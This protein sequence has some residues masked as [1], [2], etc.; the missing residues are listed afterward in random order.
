MTYL[1]MHEEIIQQNREME[2]NR[3]DV[4]DNVRVFEAKGMNLRLAAKKRMKRM[5]KDATPEQV[6][7]WCKEADKVFDATRRR[8]QRAAQMADDKDHQDGE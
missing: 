4:L 8:M 2:M 6:M 7:E 5:D 3:S 1:S